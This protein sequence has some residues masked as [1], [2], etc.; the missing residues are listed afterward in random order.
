MNKKPKENIWCADFET[1]NYEDDCRIWSWGARNVY[2]EEYVCGTDMA[3]FIKWLFHKRRIVYFHNLKFDG[4][5]IIDYLL[6]KGFTTQL[7]KKMGPKQIRPMISEQGQWY[8]IDIKGVKVSV[9]IK[10]S[11]KVIASSLESIAKSLKLDV[12]KGSID[13]EMYRPVGYQPTEEEARYQWEDCYIAACALKPLLDKGMTK[14]TAGSNALAYYKEKQFGN[15]N[16]FREKFPILTKEEDEWLR[17]S[18]RGGITMVKKGEECKEQGEGIV[19][20]INSMYPWAMHSPNPYPVG[21]P[22]WGTGEPPE[23]KLYIVHVWVLATKKPDKPPTIQLKKSRFDVGAEYAD[24]IPGFDLYLAKPDLHMLLEMY[25]IEDIMYYEY[26]YFNQEVGLF[27]SYIDEFYALKASS[28]AEGNHTE[29]MR[30]KLYLNSLYGKFATRI[31]GRSKIPELCEDGVVRYKAGELEEREGVYLP[32]GIFVTA[33]AREKLLT[34]IADVWPRFLYCDTDSIHL[35]GH[36]PPDNL[37]IHPYKLGAWKEEMKFSKAKYLRAKLY[38]EQDADTGELV[39][40]GA[41][42]GKDVKAQATF[43]NFN[44]GHEYS[45]NLKAKVV[46]GGTV[47][48]RSDFKVRR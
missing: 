40:V 16:K 32:V 12:Q 15:E 46:P 23:D 37:E 21:R 29:T 44:L 47:L 25:D 42:M 14:L 31:E 8:K 24:E 19:L 26:C 10:D 34:S 13:Y 17:K 22:M 7:G 4:S 33:Y 11:F 27:D 43:E 1:N 39:V 45:G 36:E 41:G 20:D 5:F 35:K 48:L 38:M 2:T 18:Y 30:A 3:A 9:T 6:K 28:K